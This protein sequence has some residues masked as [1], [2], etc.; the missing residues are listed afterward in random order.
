MRI[1]AQM[2]GIDEAI[3]R[4]ER[5]GKDIKKAQPKALRAGAKILAK[6][7]KDEVNVSNIDHVHVKDDIKVRQT[8]KRNR[9]YPDAVSFDIGPGKETAWRAKFNH[10]GYIAKN[11]RYVS[12]NPFGSKAFKAKKSAIN[13]AVLRELQRE[14]R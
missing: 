7:M 10:D 12:G 9:I 3:A 6:A 11:G 14:L 5:A 13:Q 4:L 1:S 8:P 2:Q